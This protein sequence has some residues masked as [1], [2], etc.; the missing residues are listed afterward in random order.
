MKPTIEEQLQQLKPVYQS[1][2]ASPELAT[3][4]QTILQQTPKQKSHAMLRFGRLAACLLLGLFIT[5]TAALNLSP[6]F[7]ATA[8]ELPVI[9]PLAQ[10]LTWR[11][12][13]TSDENAQLHAT[14]PQIADLTDAEL[15][16]LINEQIQTKMA[17]AIQAA[18]QDAA[19]RRQAFIETGGDP[20]DF[21]PVEITA[22]YTI[23][24]Q[25]RSYL[26][27]VVTCTE[28]QAQGNVTEYYYNLDLTKNQPV[29]LATMLG[30]DYETI[31]NQQIE[32]QIAAREKANPA[33]QYFHDN[34]MGFAGISPQQNFYINEAGHVVIVFAKYE[35][36][37]GY[38]GPQTFEILPE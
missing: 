9:G 13:Q 3:K 26:S 20:A 37:P 15:Q 38:M 18:E 32:A 28:T 24:C 12:Y 19:E 5:G 36:A 2:E 22:D 17:A 11:E 16:A 31:C 25:N 27:F 4:L 34:G 21:I 14:I 10:V 1:I 33:D 35:I 7:A 29:T 30:A 23:Y 8:A 6:A